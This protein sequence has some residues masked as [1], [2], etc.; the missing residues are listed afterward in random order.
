MTH[1]PLGVYSDQCPDTWNKRVFTEK[2]IWRC[3]YDLFAKSFEL[4]DVGC[5]DGAP[6]SSNKIQLVPNRKEAI[7]VDYEEHALFLSDVESKTRKSLHVFLPTK[8]WSND[9][10]MQA[11]QQGG[12]LRAQRVWGPALTSVGEIAEPQ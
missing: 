1:V 12:E 3:T 8:P 6:V 4:D 11:R 5:E 7:C 2:E 9:K 10:N